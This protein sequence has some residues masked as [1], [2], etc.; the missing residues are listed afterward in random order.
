MLYLRWFYNATL[1][2]GEM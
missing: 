1:L 2:R